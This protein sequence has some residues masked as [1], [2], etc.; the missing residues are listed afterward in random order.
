MAVDGNLL[1]NKAI[2]LLNLEEYPLIYAGV[3]PGK[4]C[5]DRRKNYGCG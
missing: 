5:S 1:N 3:F 2:I 4:M